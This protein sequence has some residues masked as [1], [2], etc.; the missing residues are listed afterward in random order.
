MDLF[1]VIK[2]VIELGYLSNVHWQAQRPAD[3]KDA[4]FPLDKSQRHYCLP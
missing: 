3:L 4:L 2:F 1:D